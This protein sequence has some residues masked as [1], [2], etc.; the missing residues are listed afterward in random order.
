VAPVSRDHDGAAC[1]R[2][3]RNRR[4]DQLYID[5]VNNS[6]IDRLRECF[7]ENAWWACTT[8]DGALVQHPI[9][10]S[11]ENWVGA[12]FTKDWQHRILSVTQAGDVASVVLEMHSASNPQEHW[13]DIHALLRLDG[14]WKDMNKTATHADRAGWAGAL[15]RP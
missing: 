7:H 9:A 12:D 13:V 6:D 15:P 10:E 4:S 14:V 11:L 1:S 3:R 8:A 2:P 5:G